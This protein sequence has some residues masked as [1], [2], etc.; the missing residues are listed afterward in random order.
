MQALVW[1]LLRACLACWAVAVVGS[2]LA[3]ARVSLDDG[4]Q[5][6]PITRYVAVLE[7][8]SRQA[9]LES[10]RTTGDW[11]LW[12]REALNFGLSRSTWWLRVS[13]HNSTDMPHAYV[14]DLGTTQQDF[15]QWY[16]FGIGDA[17]PLATGA[18]G[19]FLDFR[20]RPVSTRTL[21]I[22]LPLG[23]GESRDVY[24][25]LDTSGTAFSVLNLGVSEQQTFVA[26]EQFRDLWIGVFY[27]VVALSAFMG[28]LWFLAIYW[29]PT[30]YFSLFVLFFGFYAAGYW[31]TDMQHVLPHSP[32]FL[33]HLKVLAGVVALVCG[34]AAG[35]SFVRMRQ[36]VNRTT[37]LV[38]LFFAG[39]TLVT[40]V[41]VALNDLRVSEV[42]ALVS[43]AALFLVGAVVLAAL[44]RRRVLYAAPLSF[45]YIAISTALGG[46]AILLFGVVDAGPLLLDFIPLAVALT[47]GVLALVFAAQVRT[48]MKTQTFKQAR[49]SM[50]RYVAHDIRAPQS[51]ILALLGRTHANEMPDAIKQAI[52]DQVERTVQLTEAFLWLSKAE[53]SVYRFEPVLLGDLV[54]QATDLV[55]PLFEK[56][57]IGLEREGW[58]DAEI[59]IEADREM[60]ARCL[61]NLLENAA[62]Y[63]PSGTVVRLRIHRSSAGVTLSIQDQG[64]GMDADFVKHAFADYQRSKNSFGELGFGLGLAFVATVLDQH[65]VNWQ[66]HSQPGAG[67]T[68]VLQFRTTAAAPA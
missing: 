5:R 47:L 19:D 32:E 60:M 65:T 18:V 59:W 46:R 8:P 38:L 12:Q 56:K 53:S 14:L 37:Y 68:F 31:G 45:I 58:D 24:L 39:L 25:R 26:K 9:T 29:A 50:V 1:R 20:L 51:A 6:L 34:N 22:P 43:G 16:V 23:P 67:S 15:V 64:Q 66:C 62:K 4:T 7:D 61:F 40:L 49:L 21:A 57:R 28:L 3:L 35:M 41:P 27:G 17:H 55:W 30:A 44:A 33:H 42:W 63:S 11:H 10:V 2:P 36:H 13:V 48:Q 52:Q 54:H